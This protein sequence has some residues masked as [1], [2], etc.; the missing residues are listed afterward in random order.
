[1]SEPPSASENPVRQADR[2]LALARALQPPPTPADLR[3]CVIA[4]IARERPVDLMAERR[5]LEAQHRAALNGLNRH[6][7]RRGRDAL[8]LGSGLLALL[9]FSIG[10]LSHRLAP[11]CNDAAPT[12]AGFAMLLVGTVGGAI[13]WQ[14]WLRQSGALHSG[15]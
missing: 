8:L 2:E 14:E 7:L 15:R 9:G 4:A 5:E 13:L 12:V 3:A 10:P 6:Y 1:M 11:L